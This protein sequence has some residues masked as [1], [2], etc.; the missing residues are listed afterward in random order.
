[1]PCYCEKLIVLA[2]MWS[3]QGCE[4]LHGLS[5]SFRFARIIEKKYPIQ[6]VHQVLQ[7]QQFLYLLELHL[8]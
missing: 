5:D 2:M 7:L 3:G 6:P 1:M 8:F 4:E